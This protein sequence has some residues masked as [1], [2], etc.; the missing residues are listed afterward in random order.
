MNASIRGKLPF[1]EN[2]KTYRGSR[3]LTY[4]A[5]LNYHFNDWFTFQASYLGIYQSYAYWAGELDINTGLR[6]GMASIG[7]SVLT[8]YNLPIS[9]AVVLPLHQETLYDDTNALLDGVYEERDA[10]EFGPLVSLTVLYAF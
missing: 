3:E 1:Y 6:F 5:G 8:P 2:S 4:T 7:A 9:V 10:F